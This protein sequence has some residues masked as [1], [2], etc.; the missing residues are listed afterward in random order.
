MLLLDAALSDAWE[1]LTNTSVVI[2]H[3]P[4]P[5]N[6]VLDLVVLRC[7]LAGPQ[8]RVLR[9]GVTPPAGAVLPPSA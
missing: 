1:P 6:R 5:T 4:R 7:D 3:D 9:A 8:S 2:R